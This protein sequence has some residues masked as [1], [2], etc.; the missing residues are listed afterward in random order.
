M[1][2]LFHKL[3]QRRVCL[4]LLVGIVILASGMVLGSGG[5]I[6]Y[7]KNRVVFRGGP[8]RFT[9]EKIVKHFE[10]KYRLSQQQSEQVRQLFEEMGARYREKSETDRLQRE[11]DEKVMIAK[12]QDILSPEQYEQWKQDFDEIKKHRHEMYE[13]GR[14]RNGGPERSGPHRRE[15][16]RPPA[17]RPPP[18]PLAPES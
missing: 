7:M 15:P 4:Q 1:V 8:D 5:T 13:R 2:G 10:E 3:R 17:H 14:P 16:N 11:A 18:P 9:P 6:L 12:M